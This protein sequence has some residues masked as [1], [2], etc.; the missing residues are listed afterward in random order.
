LVAHEK[1]EQ[2]KVAAI[3]QKAIHRSAL[4]RSFAAGIERQNEQKKTRVVRTRFSRL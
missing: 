4:N 2:A 3:T 1:A